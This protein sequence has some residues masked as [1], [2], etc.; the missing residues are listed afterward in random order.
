MKWFESWFDTAYYH[1]LYAHRDDAEAISFIDVLMGYLQLESGSK[2]VDVACGKGRHAAH[3]ASLGFHVLGIDLSQNSIA[4][5]NAQGAVNAQFFCHDM[6]DKFPF[7]GCHAVVNLFTSFGYF[8]T[9]MEDQL[10]LNNMSSVLINGGFVVQDYLNTQSILSELHTANQTIN[11]GILVPSLSDKTTLQVGKFAFETH[12]YPEGNF[13]VKD[14]R[15]HDKGVLHQF[16]ERV[17]MYTKEELMRLHRGAGLEVL[18]VFGDYGL[19]KFDANSSP[20]III[21]SQK[22]GS[23]HKK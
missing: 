1:A 10:V 19:G 11:R 21:V 23:L 14:I 4:E 15:V 5:A 7:F 22:S 17:R 16:Q 2:V 18:T 12:K 13:I 9:K 6:R 8:E 20:R 3:L